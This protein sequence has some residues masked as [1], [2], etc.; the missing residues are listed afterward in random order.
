MGGRN[1]SALVTAGRDDIRSTRLD[2]NNCSLDAPSAPVLGAG[3]SSTRSDFLAA[4]LRRRGVQ[5]GSGRGAVGGI[6]ILTVNADGV[7][8]LE[9]VERPLRDEDIVTAVPVITAE[10]VH[11]GGDEDGGDNDIALAGVDVHLSTT[12]FETAYLVSQLNGPYHE[13]ALQL[14]NLLNSTP[15]VQTVASTTV[16]LQVGARRMAIILQQ[17]CLLGYLWYWFGFAV[18]YRLVERILAGP[19][20]QICGFVVALHVVYWMTPGTLKAS[21]YYRLP[22]ARDGPPSWKVMTAISCIVLIDGTT[23]IYTANKGNHY[24]YTYADESGATSEGMLSSNAGL[25]WWHMPKETTEVAAIAKDGPVFVAPVYPYCVR[26]TEP[27]A[28]TQDLKVL[29]GTPLRSEFSFTAT[30]VETN[31]WLSNALGWSDKQ[32][33]DATTPVSSY[34]VFKCGQVTTSDERTTSRNNCTE[35]SAQ[36]CYKTKPSKISPYISSKYISS[37]SSGDPWKGKIEGSADG[38]AT[39]FPLKREYS[40][41]QNDN[42]YLWD[43]SGK[44]SDIYLFRS[45]YLTGDSTVATVSSTSTNYQICRSMF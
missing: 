41:F 39:Y 25:G 28:N 36:I 11:E 31:T 4:G 35:R 5:G 6:N 15:S 40:P 2:G 17:V 14:M 33:G 30:G 27:R 38:G 3:T 34:G 10:P 22:Y 37:K 13:K 20:M 45:K 16:Y 7:V 32:L 44:S 18:H 12:R 26:V 8:V 19:L 21:K 24:A 1:I 29:V 43:F 9:N 23:Q 42:I